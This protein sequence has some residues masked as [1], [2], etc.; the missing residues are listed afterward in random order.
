MS[1]RLKDETILAREAIQSVL[2]TATQPLPARDIAQHPEVACL[3]LPVE[4][5]VSIVHRM[6]KRKTQLFPLA[7]VQWHG[8]GRTEHAYYNPTVVD[9]YGISK[10]EVNDVNPT[11]EPAPPGE[12]Q[13]NP[14]ELVQAE[15]QRVQLPAAKRITLEVSGVSIHIELTH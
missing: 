8:P 11:E 2:A 3:G 7:R 12:F 9:P 6:Y 15:E 4:Q 13:F 10:R 5:V 14:V 1:T